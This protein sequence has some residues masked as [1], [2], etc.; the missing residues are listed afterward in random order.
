MC[1][2]LRD[3]SPSYLT[4]PSYLSMAGLAGV[5]LLWE[6]DIIEQRVEDD[7]P[8][9]AHLQAP[10]EEPVLVVEGGLLEATPQLDMLA[11]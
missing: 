1:H 8:L 10:A 11:I 4:T 6:V 7:P 3:T 2:L 5:L 9:H